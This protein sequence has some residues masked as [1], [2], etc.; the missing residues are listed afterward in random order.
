MYF[1]QLNT[2]KNICI[3]AEM[4]IT[5]EIKKNTRSHYNTDNYAEKK[6]LNCHEN[7]FTN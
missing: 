7:T 4:K 3:I 6:V 2:I 5:F 1:A